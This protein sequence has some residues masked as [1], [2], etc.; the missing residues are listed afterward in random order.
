MYC[1]VTLSY[2]TSGWVPVILRP[3]IAMATESNKQ[4]LKTVPATQMGRAHPQRQSSMYH[5]AAKTHRWAGNRLT[6]TTHIPA[7]AQRDNLHTVS[8]NITL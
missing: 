5:T 3:E 7:W 4:T 8:A 6:Y 1:C 2:S